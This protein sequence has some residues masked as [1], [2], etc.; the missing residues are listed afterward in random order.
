MKTS[1]KIEKIK[2]E[3][4]KILEENNFLYVSRELYI[5]GPSDNSKL[6]RVGTSFWTKKNRLSKYKSESGL[7]LEIKFLM[8]GPK[9]EINKIEGI[10]HRRLRPWKRS[11]VKYDRGH[12]SWYEMDQKECIEKVKDVFRW[13]GYAYS[14]IHRKQY[15]DHFEDYVFDQKLGACFLSYIMD[16]PFRSTA[17][18]DNFVFFNHLCGIIFAKPKLPKYFNNQKARYDIRNYNSKIL[19]YIKKNG[20]DIKIY[21]SIKSIKKDNL[22]LF[23]HHEEVNKEFKLKIENGKSF[24]SFKDAYSYIQQKLIALNFSNI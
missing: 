1:E 13:K 11:K 4:I 22:K 18:F 2:E 7:D 23:K 20:F 24:E 8:E 14:L 21:D 10:I 9:N 19:K 3:Y 6:C 15:P 5:I 16:D 12:G 17:G